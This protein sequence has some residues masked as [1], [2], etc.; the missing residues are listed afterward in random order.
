[1]AASYDLELLVRSHRDDGFGVTRRLNEQIRQKFILLLMTVPGERVMNGDFGVGLSQYLFHNE[2]EWDSGMR[3]NLVN[4]ITRQVQNYMAYIQLESIEIFTESENYSLGVEIEYSVPELYDDPSES[5]VTLEFKGTDG[6][7]IDVVFEDFHGTDDLD[8][9][10]YTGP[11]SGRL[12]DYFI[13][14]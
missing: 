1:M 2:S 7:V 6:G 13:G 14:D 11:S 8:E 9:D 5:R 4:A 12:G 3:S 10:L